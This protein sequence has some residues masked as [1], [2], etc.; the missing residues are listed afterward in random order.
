MKFKHYLETISNV[1]IY[2]MFSLIVFFVF[3]VGL[4]YYVVKADKKHIQ[5][6]QDIP[7]QENN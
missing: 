1:E 7:F 5:Y 2:P 3:F 6:M 4:I